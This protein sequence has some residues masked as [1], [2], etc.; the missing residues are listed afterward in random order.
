MTKTILIAL[1][2]LLAVPNF[3]KRDINGTAVYN[4]K[5]R[6]NPELSSIQSIDELEAYVDKAAAL[7]NFT[8]GSGEYA[9]L[10]AYV[11][12]CRFY[13]GFSHW[14]VNENW[15]AAVSEKLIGMGLASKVQPDEIM[16]HP[17]AACSQQAMVMMEIL[18][19]KNV[20]YRKVGFPHHYAL[21]AN[22]A[23][24]WY[25]FD[26]NMEPKIQFTERSHESWKGNNDIIKSYYSKAKHENLNF[27]FGRGETAQLGAI[28]EI[29]ARNAKIFQGITMVLSKCLWLVPFLLSFAL[30]KKPYMY[31]VKPI[32]KNYTPPPRL[33]PV[34]Y[35]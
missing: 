28:N 10:L 13:H 29:P 32:N 15:I 3:I 20:P 26:P 27:Q 34:Y 4:Q 16:K 2:I 23:G 14:K 11:V 25:F 5:E 21:E 1:A 33:R 8:P 24:E 9:T 7:K 22:I 18:K 12:S 17:N 35:A 6:Y 19:R 30:K 31:A